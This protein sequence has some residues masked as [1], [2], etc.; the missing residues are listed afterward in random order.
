MAPEAGPRVPILQPREWLDAVRRDHSHPCIVAWVPF[1]ESWGVPNLPEN[2][3][4]PPHFTPM[5]R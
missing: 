5:A 1:N 2:P 4:E 3:S